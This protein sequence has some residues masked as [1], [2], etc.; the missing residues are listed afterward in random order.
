MIGKIRDFVRQAIRVL[1]ISYHPTSEEF[2]MTA[3]ITGFGM[4]AIGVIGFVITLI[5]G[6]IDKVG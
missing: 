1:N 3:K 2:N 5:F 6:V 4:I